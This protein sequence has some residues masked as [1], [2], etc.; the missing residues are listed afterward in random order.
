MKHALFFLAA[1]ALATLAYSN[2]PVQ[3]DPPIAHTV[4]QP[5]D[6]TNPGGTARL[7]NA[8]NAT[9]EIDI[10]VMVPPEPCESTYSYVV[11][12]GAYATMTGFGGF[13]GGDCHS[14]HVRDGGT[15]EVI[16]STGGTF[17]VDHGG[18]LQIYVELG[19]DPVEVVEEYSPGDWQTVVVQPGTI[20]TSP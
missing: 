3:I 13:S 19:S 12:G 5:G 16:V 18:T 14:M 10:F 4:L 7:S 11:H 15:A 9:G 20:Y 17:Q 2:A 1:L 8:S 6:S